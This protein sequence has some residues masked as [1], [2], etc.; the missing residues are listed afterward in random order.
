MRRSGPVLAGLGVLAVALAGEL[1]QGRLA[2]PAAQ[3][4]IAETRAIV[5]ALGLSDPAL[6]T[7]ARYTRHPALAD[8]NTPFQDHPG[9]FDRFPTGSIVPLQDLPGGHELR[10]G[11]GGGS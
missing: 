7:E 6:F 5:A 3:A 2:A 9:A 8:L 10:I 4:R 11:A 1:V